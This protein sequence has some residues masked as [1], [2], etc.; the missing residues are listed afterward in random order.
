MKH[1]RLIIAAS[2][3]AL[4][5]L[6]GC[7]TGGIKEITLCEVTHS[8]FYAPQYVAINKGFFEEEGL[9]VTLV[10]GAGADKV[11]TA[12]LSGQ[13]DI[14]FSGPEACVYV[15]NEGKDDY[16]IVFA[17]LT[18]RDGSFLV[19]REPMPD[20]KWDDV[21]GKKIIGGRKGSVPE[22]TLEYVLKKNN[23][24]PCK[25]VEIDTS[26]QFALM[27][28]AFLSGQGD[29]VTLFEPVASSFEREKTGYIVCSIGQESGE[30]P[31]TAYYAK[32][33][34]IEKNPDIIQSFTNAIYKGQQWVENHSDREVAEALQESF[35]E[36]DLELL[37]IV[38][39][40]YKTQD[41]WNKTPVM[42]EEAFNRLQEVMKEAGE[43]KEMAPY[44]KIV[45][46]TYA[47]NA[48]K[49]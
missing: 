23:I 48:M 11:M 3:L 5:L 2:L 26:I 37:E 47:E 28:G 22:M 6:T 27:G 31:Y 1:K 43:L 19:G 24:I 30:I 38:V 36:S 7:G 40:R 12:V 33:S 42:K 4:L 8:I 41:A 45:D 25:D 49:K 17:Q 39:N 9:K 20:F 34:Y 44:D 29:F 16:G 46:N 13:A 21:R 32:K 18:K 14:G 35:P 10:N 15:Y